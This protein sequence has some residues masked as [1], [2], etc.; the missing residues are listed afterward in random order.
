MSD[1]VSIEIGH[2]R[3]LIAEDN[4]VNAMVLQKTLARWGL[5]ADVAT[6]GKLALDAVI[7]NCYDLIFM[8]TNMPVISGFD[9]SRRIRELS[10]PQKSQVCIIALIASIW[11]S[12]EEHPELRY[13]D[14]FLVKP[15][16]VEQLKEK[17]EQIV[18]MGQSNFQA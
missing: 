18:R 2:L 11:I 3:I 5:V 6:K 10:D 4:P 13:L 15:F 8:D 9:V 14:D 12:L 1:E 16:S 17:L 7:A